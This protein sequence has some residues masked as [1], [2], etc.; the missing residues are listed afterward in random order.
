MTV[1]NQLRMLFEDENPSLAAIKDEMEKEHG[2]S[3]MRFEG[4]KLVAQGLTSL[5]EV[6]RVTMNLG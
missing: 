4:F 2:S 1:T 5:D 3:L 6:E